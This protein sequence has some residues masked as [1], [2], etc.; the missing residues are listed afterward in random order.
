[1]K[2]ATEVTDELTRLLSDPLSLREIEMLELVAIDVVTRFYDGPK[3]L[4]S[5]NI[6]RM[7][8]E[9]RAARGCWNDET[10]TQAEIDREISELRR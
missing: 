2:T 7:T 4:H 5:K 8:A 9:I 10:L 3:L 1:M 6:L